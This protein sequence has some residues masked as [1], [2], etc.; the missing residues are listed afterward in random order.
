MV[1][2]PN[3]DY[4]SSNRGMVITAE[5]ALAVIGSIVGAVF[6][7]GFLAF[8]LWSTLII[9]GALLLLN[10]L[11]VYQL[12]QA[13]FSHLAKV[14]L[15][16]VA[17]WALFYLI[18][19]IISFVPTFWTPDA[20]IGYVEFALFLLDGFFH[21]RMYRSGGATEPPVEPLPADTGH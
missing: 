15:G 10:I 7:S 11:N 20:I 18:S 2:Q 9:S 21:F 19:T 5:A 13:K 12:L 4:L 8:C 6:Q 14:E 3:L 1:F 17:V 16:Y